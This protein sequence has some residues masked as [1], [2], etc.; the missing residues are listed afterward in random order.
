MK[1]AVFE[2]NRNLFIYEA[3]D[4]LRANKLSEAMALALERLSVFPADADAHVV[5][6]SALVGLG[7]V[8]DARE[9]MLEFGERLSEMALVYERVGDLYR[10]KGFYRDAADCYEKLLALHPD[11]QKAR[12]IITKMSLLEQ[13]DRPLQDAPVDE[14]FEKSIPEPEMFTVTM[15][16]LYIQQ[17]H[18]PEAV[19][20]LEEILR[21]DPQNTEAAETLNNL[22]SA[23]LDK[24][25]L[26][27]TSAKNQK[28]IET[29][30]LWLQN[31]ERLKANAQRLP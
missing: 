29:L 18:F 10:K 19:K 20:I 15:A 1:N 17:G 16:D 28:L 14:L 4:L 23:V 21:K 9:A 7:R 24:P 2:R 26:K 25:E 13:E 3:E 12:D 27:K 22:R 8:E 6:C 5:L 31:I 11:A 30:S